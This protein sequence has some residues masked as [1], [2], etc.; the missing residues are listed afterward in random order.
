MFGMITCDSKIAN[1]PVWLTLILDRERSMKMLTGGVKR[2]EGGKV[3]EAEGK[4]G[5]HIF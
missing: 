1:L 4:L 5:I 3:V 2:G